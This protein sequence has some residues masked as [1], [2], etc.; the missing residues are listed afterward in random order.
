MD[1]SMYTKIH[2]LEGNIA[3]AI[4]QYSIAFHFKVIENDCI[5]AKGGVYDEILP[6]PL[7]NPLGSIQ[8]QDLLCNSCD[9]KC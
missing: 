3:T 1:Q 5:V 9:K 7:G 4:F 6:E 8:L 2:C